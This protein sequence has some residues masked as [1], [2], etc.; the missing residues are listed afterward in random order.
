MVHRIRSIPLRVDE[1]REER[2]GSPT[3]WQTLT[4]FWIIKSAHCCRKHKPMFRTDSCIDLIPGKDHKTSGIPVAKKIETLD[5]QSS[6]PAFKIFV[7]I[8]MHVFAEL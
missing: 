6:V 1:V 2:T 4:S 7:K 3:V 8:L 5:D